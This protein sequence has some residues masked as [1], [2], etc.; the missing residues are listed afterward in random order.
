MLIIISNPTS[1]KD[2]H[3]IVNQLFDDGLEYFQLYKPSFSKEETEIF[4]DQ[5]EKIY[6]HRIVLHAQ[7]LKFHS[8]KELENC[9]EKYDYAF[10]SPIFDSISKI[11][12]KS[13]FDLREIKD[14]FK[15]RKEK[16]IALGGIDEDK[17]D[18]IKDL[19]FHGIALLGA[20]W[21]NENP[22]RKFKQ[23][24]EKWQKKEFVY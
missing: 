9:T 14:F 1:I 13:K 2:E 8:L 23:V 21:Q 15:N 4:I 19:G 18:I 10:L 24:R 7:Y 5:I 20:I 22:V 11:G 12:Y 3:E 16:I 17:I 6:H